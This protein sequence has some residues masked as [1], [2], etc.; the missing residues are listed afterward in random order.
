MLFTSYA[1]IA[2]IAVAFLLYYIIPKRL[3]WIFLL[4]ISI[5]FYASAGVAYPIFLI[6]S[7]AATY[8]AGMWIERERREEKK[9]LREHADEFSSREEK[10]R[11][12][13]K[14]EKRC[15]AIMLS[16]LLT[17]LIILG[18]FKYADFVIDNINE[19]FYAIG[20]DQEIDYLDLLLP[21]GISFYTFQSLGYLLDVYWEK[22]E[23]QKN[24]FKHLLFVS[25]FPQVVQGPISRY[26]DL[27]QTLYYEHNFD[28]KQVV[29]GW[30]RS[31]W[32]CIK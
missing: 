25:F 12:K 22:I 4:I 5:G 9:Y 30:A 31:F 7:S 21:M 6:I 28:K 15:K 10:K 29:V 3:Q 27:S 17:L 16:A 23:A 19:I 18:V 8:L 24:F 1:F 2:F 14:R 32:A 20:V 11:F 13:K 26:S